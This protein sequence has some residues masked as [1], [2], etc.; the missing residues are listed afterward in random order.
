[1]VSGSSLKDRVLELSMKVFTSYK[2]FSA[3]AHTSTLKVKRE[4]RGQPMAAIPLHP[5]RCLETRS[6]A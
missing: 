1:M 5:L 3:P 6:L 4:C 2:S